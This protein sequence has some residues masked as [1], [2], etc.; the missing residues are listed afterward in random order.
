M[1]TNQKVIFW[2][3]NPFCGQSFPPVIFLLLNLPVT[4]AKEFRKN[5][6]SSMLY[7][8]FSTPIGDYLFGNYISS[9]PLKC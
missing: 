5:N 6:L 9:L 1:Q 7:P 2:S 4:T 3:Y 8:Y